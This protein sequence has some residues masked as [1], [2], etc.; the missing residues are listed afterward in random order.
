MNLGLHLGRHDVRERGFSEPRS[1]KEQ[2]VVE[3]LATV[4]RSADEDPEIG[5]EALLADELSESP[6][7][8]GLLIRTLFGRS[9]VVRTSS[10]TV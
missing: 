1:A 9:S 6:W 3:R 8:E 10:V 7:S 4:A 2:R 5:L